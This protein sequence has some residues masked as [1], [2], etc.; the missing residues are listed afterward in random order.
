MG[1]RVRKSAGGANAEGADQALREQAKKLFRESF[2]SERTGVHETWY[3]AGWRD[4]L[5]ELFP[6]VDVDEER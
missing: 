4:A 1:K 5:R 3:W 6:D 2:E